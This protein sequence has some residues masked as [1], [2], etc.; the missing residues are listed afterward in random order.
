MIL[1]ELSSSL[2]I[3]NGRILETALI[4]FDVLSRVQWL[5]IIS[6]H[7]S[8]RILMKSSKCDVT[9]ILSSTLSISIF[10]SSIPQVSSYLF[11]SMTKLSR[12]SKIISNNQSFF[13]P[14]A[15]IYIPTDSNNL[16]ENNPTACFDSKNSTLF[17]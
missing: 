15:Q 5:T 8:S 17:F 11:I 9:F 7:E 13:Y 3:K 1:I 2:L 12:I 16:F 4:F 14:S 10:S 6:L